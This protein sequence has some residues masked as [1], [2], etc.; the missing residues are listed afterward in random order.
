MRGLSLHVKNAKHLTVSKSQQLNISES[1]SR[2][3]CYRWIT[4]CWIIRN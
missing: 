1:E 2:I 4:K 3:V